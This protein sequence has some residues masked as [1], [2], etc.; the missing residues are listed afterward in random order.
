MW[1]YIITV[2]AHRLAT[3]K[4]G[5]LLI[6]CLAKALNIAQEASGSTV[7]SPQRVEWRRLRENGLRLVTNSS[8][9]ADTVSKRSKNSNELDLATQGFIDKEIYFE[10]I[11]TS[12]A[13]RS[14]SPSTA[15]HEEQLPTVSASS[16]SALN[17]SLLA[18]SNSTS[19]A[20]TSA[21]SI[22]PPPTFPSISQPAPPTLA[23]A[24]AVPVV[25]RGRK[26]KALNAEKDQRKRSSGRSMLAGSDTG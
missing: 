8:I 1:L 22:L 21:E 12:N 14:V 20:P 10:I 24:V 9:T 15:L 19:A 13:Q 4:N 2:S 17:E 5:C 7:T 16:F 25:Q 3:K 18:T 26:R 23:V 6:L 11:S